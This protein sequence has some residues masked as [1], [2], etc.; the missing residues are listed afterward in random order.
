[1]SGRIVG[2]ILDNAPQDLTQLEL[3]VLVAIGEEAREKDRTARYN[4]S[5]EAIAHRVRSTPATVRNVL[6]RLRHRALIIPVHEKV[7]RGLAQQ[8]VLPK[9]AEHH[10]RATLNGTPQRH[11]PVAQ[12]PDESATTR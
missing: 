4:T 1:M 5:A 3:L 10:R 7:Y 11:P 8:Y 12:S 9:Y 6:G 2:E